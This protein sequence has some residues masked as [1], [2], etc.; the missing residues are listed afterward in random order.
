MQTSGRAAQLCNDQRPRRSIVRCFLYHGAHC[1]LLVTRL[2]EI[3]MVTGQKFNAL[4]W[5]ADEVYRR[6]MRSLHVL[7]QDWVH[8]VFSDGCLFKEINLLVRADHATSREDYEAFLKSDL[9]FP[10]WMNTKGSALWRI[11]DSYRND[12]NDTDGFQLK[13]DASEMLGLYI[14]LRHF[15]ELSFNGRP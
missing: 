12:D 13:G 14:L 9:I 5:Y 8:G 6:Y 4:A 7:N 2:N 15:V 10:G 3:E 11:F 1:N